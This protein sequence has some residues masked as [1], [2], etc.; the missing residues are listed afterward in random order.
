MGGF[1]EE[2]D[3]QRTTRIYYDEQIRI[4]ARKEAKQLEE[5]IDGTTAAILVGVLLLVFIIW[6]AVKYIFI[7]VLLGVLLM[8]FVVKKVRIAKENKRIHNEYLAKMKAIKEEKDKEELKY[9]RRLEQI[10][11]EYKT[12][13]RCFERAKIDGKRVLAIG[14]TALGITLELQHDRG[15]E[16]MFLF[17]SNFKKYPEPKTLD[18]NIFNDANPDIVFLNIDIFEEPLKFLNSL[19]AAKND[20]LIIPHTL[21]TEVACL[22]DNNIPLYKPTTVTSLINF[23]IC[24]L[25][26]VEAPKLK[27]DMELVKVIET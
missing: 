16:T 21:K 19:K 9:K 14:R 15:I 18:I 13:E 25:Y 20:V 11:N 23:G 5:P 22:W 3:I 27:K 6:L 1:D 24:A 2:S 7:G 8:L 26:R 17:E 10:H 4:Q 12:I